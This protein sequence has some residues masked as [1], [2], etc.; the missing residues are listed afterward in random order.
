MTDHINLTQL[1]ADLIKDIDRF[2][3]TLTRYTT[4]P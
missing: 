1:R 3:E 4:T 2:L